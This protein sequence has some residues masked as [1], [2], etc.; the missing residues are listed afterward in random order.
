MVA[1]E[2]KKLSFT[3]CTKD[4]LCSLVFNEQEFFALLNAYLTNI[5]ELQLSPDHLWEFKTKSAKI[6]IFLKQHLK[7][8]FPDAD[9][10][11][12][13]N[14]LKKANSRSTYLIQIQIKHFNKFDKLLKNIDLE[15]INIKRAY[16]AGVFLSCGSVSDPEGKYKHLELRIQNQIVKKTTIEILNNLNLA[17]AEIYRRNRFV[18]YFKKI[19]IISDFLKLICAEKSFYHYEDLKIARDFGIAV[20]RLNNL[21]V[22]NLNKTI[23]TNQ[24]MINIIE[25]LRKTSYY[26]THLNQNDRTY[27]KVL[28]SNPTYN[29]EELLERFNK[30]SKKPLTKSGLNHIKR[31]IKQVYLDANLDLKK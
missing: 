27:C 13:Q 31:K 28:L 16:L 12:Y 5:G 2:N 6:A 30:L 20:Q 18:I 14:E 4:D 19:D 23:K 3:E 8:Y 10:I 26:S 1:V 21:E 24:E 11:V 22:S 17:Y 15:Q 9:L 7:K 29:L 25:K